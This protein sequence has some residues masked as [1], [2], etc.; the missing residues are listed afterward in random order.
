MFDIDEGDKY[1]SVLYH[2]MV[3]KDD[4]C[5]NISETECRFCIDLY[6]QLE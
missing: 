1:G 3:Y 6:H 5:E 4:D 2:V